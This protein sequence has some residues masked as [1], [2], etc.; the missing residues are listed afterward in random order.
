[1]KNKKIYLAII[2]SFIFGALFTSIIFNRDL[3]N[4]PEEYLNKVVLNYPKNMDRSSAQWFMKKNFMGEWEN[5]MFIFGYVD[6]RSV[7]EFMLGIAKET[8]P[9][10]E[11]RC[12]DVN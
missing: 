9:E 10:I 11:F 1:M 4:K 5:L 7:C 3:K 2:I 12:K 8:D 6:D